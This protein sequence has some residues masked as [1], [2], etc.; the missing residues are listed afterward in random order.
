MELIKRR[1]IEAWDDAD[2]LVED[3][4]LSDEEILEILPSMLARAKRIRALL[5]K[6]FSQS[7]Y[8]KLKKVL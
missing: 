1:I 3:F 2:E 6:E 8:D 4:T 5:G 7:D